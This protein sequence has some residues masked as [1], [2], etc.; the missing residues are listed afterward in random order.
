MPSFAAAADPVEFF[1]RR[2]DSYSRFI[3]LVQ[4]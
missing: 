3:R 4:Y 2:M 1:T